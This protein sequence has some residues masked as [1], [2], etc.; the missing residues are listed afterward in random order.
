MVTKEKEKVNRVYMKQIGF[1][2]GYDLYARASCPHCYG[3]GHVG[4]LKGTNQLIPCRC[5][6]SVKHQSARQTLETTLREKK[7]KTNAGA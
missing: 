6:V 3:R 2:Q 4:K 5:L 1:Y 7:E